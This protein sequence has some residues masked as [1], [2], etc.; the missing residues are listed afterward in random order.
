MPSWKRL[1]RTT[2]GT[3][4]PVGDVQGMAQNHPKSILPA[5]GV[6]A[7]MAM[8]EGNLIFVTLY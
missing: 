7:L 6:K 2:E 3:S 8:G 4:G 5:V 1:K